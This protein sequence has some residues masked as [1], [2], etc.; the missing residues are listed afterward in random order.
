MR[1][2]SF[3]VVY[4]W[5]WTGKRPRQWLPREKGQWWV[6]WMARKWLLQWRPRKGICCLVCSPWG[7]QVT[8]LGGGRLEWEWPDMA[9]KRRKADEG[10]SPNLVEMSSAYLEKLLPLI[11]HCAAR[12]YDDGSPREPGWITIKTQG[13][14]WVVQVKDPDT[15]CSF[16]SVAATIDNA[17]ETAAIMLASDE[18]PWERDAFLEAANARKK[19][20]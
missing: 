11:E 17:L 8:G 15:A 12:Q 18:A 6:G 1:E 9:I 3:R 5:A 19:K 7:Q 2:M 16:T 20:K 4:R 13:S 10:T 14:A